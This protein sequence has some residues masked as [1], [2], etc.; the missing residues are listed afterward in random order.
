VKGLWRSAKRGPTLMGMPTRALLVA[1]GCA[2]IFVPIG[3]GRPAD[4]CRIVP[5]KTVS[6]TNSR[7]WTVNH[8]GIFVAS[9]EYVNP[10]G[11]VWLKAPWWAAGPR[12]RA[13]RGPRGA[14]RI[15]GVRVDHV[16]PPLQAQTRQVWVDGY[17]GSAVWA[18]VITFP[19]QGCWSV[20]GRVNRT[21]HTFRLLVTKSQ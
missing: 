11:S 15:S 9:P 21:T 1:V 4:G 12:G 16:D 8:G 3:S 20:M 7:L 2:A 10:D 5:P 14:L 6:P 17:G 18:A 19:S 13:K